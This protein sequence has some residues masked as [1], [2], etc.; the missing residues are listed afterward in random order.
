MKKIALVF[1]GQG[2]QY[3]G[4]FKDLH[5]IEDKRL[6]DIFNIASNI[7]NQDFLQISSNGSNE[8]LS[9]TYIAQPIIFLHSILIDRILKLNNLNVYAVAGHSLGEY[10][11]LV[12]SGVISFED[13]LKILKVRCTE[14]EKVNKKYQGSMLAILNDDIRLIENICKNL[15]DTVI[16]NVNSQNQII[17]SGPIEQIEK[18]VELLKEN[19]IKK[20]V[21]LNVSG[22]FHSPLMREAN[23]S[24]NKVINSVNFNDSNFALYQN[25]YPNEIFDGKKIKENLKSQLCGRVNWLQI[26]KNMKTN[27]IDTIFEIGPKNVLSKLI[28]KIEPSIEVKSLDKIGDLVDSG[29]NIGIKK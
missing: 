2:S 7:F 20:I 8:K 6:L 13:C 5:T 15:K 29:F 14:M 22:A 27:N 24:L 1:P 17:I 23:V 19:N 11:A 21:K 12:S 9:S 25:V 28:K 18:S 4:M 10:T 3:L 26:I 16:A